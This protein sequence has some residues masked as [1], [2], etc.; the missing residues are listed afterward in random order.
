MRFDDLI[1]DGAMGSLLLNESGV[2]APSE[3]FNLTRP[4]LVEKIHL[5]YI[6]AGANVIYANTFGVNSY[7]SGDVNDLVQKGIS[8]AKNAVKKSQ[9]KV[10]VALDVGPTGKLLGNGGITFDQAYDSFAQ[11]IKA[12]KDA[13]IIV[14]ETFT[15]LGE[16]RAAI[17]AAKENSDLPIFA[18]MSFEKN[19][20]TAFGCSVESF[21]VTVTALGVDAIGF[22][23]SVGPIE[24]IKLFE[25]LKQNTDL[26]TF[27]KPN[28]GMPSIINGKSVYDLSPDSFA[29]AMATIKKMG[30]N[31]LGGCCGTTPKYI[32]QT[33]KAIEGIVPDAKRFS[34]VGKLCSAQ[35]VV[36]PENGLVIGERIN[37]TGKKLLQNALKN[38]DINYV[39]S[40][41]PKQEE[42]G[43][44]MLDVNLGM[45]GFDD[46]EYI[47]EVV[48][49][50]QRIT[51]CPLVIDSSN[52][53]TIEKGLRYFNGRAL[54]NS[55]NGE[56]SSLDAILPLA[57]KYGAG[58]I[59]LTLNS[60][61][62]PETVEGRVE[63]AR[64]ILNRCKEYGIDEKDVYIDCLTMSEG[65]QRGSAITTLKALKQ[66]KTLGCRTVLGVSNVSFGLPLR[67][68][69]NSAFLY[70]A[71]ESGL[72]ACIYNPK[73]KGLEP[74]E[75]AIKFLKGEIDFDEYAAY[76]TSTPKVEIEQS[77]DIYTEIR[78]GNSQEV[79][80]LVK[81]S[82]S[83]GK[84]PSA[85][86][87]SALDKIGE[88]YEA[89][90]LFL[91]QLISSAD[92]A[93]SGL[94]ILFAES[95]E[96]RNSKGTFLIATVKG[97]VHDIGK[98]IVK[99]VVSNYGYKVIDLGKDVGAEE[100]IRKIDGYYPCVLGLSALMTTTAVNMADII[101]KVRE[102]YPDIKILTGG[103]VIT[104][105]FAS[106]IG[107]IYCRDAAAAVKALN[108]I[109]N[110]K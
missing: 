64:K 33:V 29:K 100:I 78:R 13:D 2:F 65:A 31:C 30:A 98:N 85:E 80:R 66:V 71:K 62:I 94:D 102:K 106:S 92:A 42:E 95:G 48:S 58:V 56:D 39:L 51:D 37:P 16:L 15:D 34:H 28:A 21:A 5:D 24:L 53:S 88:S 57:R 103:A 70:L 3:S 67:E 105:A 52:P 1:L 46:G 26:P 89:G 91:P 22:N 84:D 107:G 50:L 74:S 32:S 104:P 19:G 73:F 82:L 25:R 110:V 45:S 59:G 75:N 35:T 96:E 63:I 27:V 9:K 93:K 90:K 43:A 76:A 54:I 20:R 49:G 41:G 97:D 101:V 72:D 44:S 36:T 81:L 86:L 4:D 11:V 10:Y 55:V 60:K 14:T 99:A 108:D 68:D 40:L 69:L 17:L 77:G 7:K 109:Y 87:F 6:N 18:S 8:I 83:E 61:G 79:K 38:G 12:G 47:S 23:C